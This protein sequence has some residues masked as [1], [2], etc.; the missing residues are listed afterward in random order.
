MPRPTHHAASRV[1]RLAGDAC[2]RARLRAQSP[3]RDGESGQALVEFALVL[4]V[5]VLFLAGIVHFGLALNGA[6]D[7]TN[8][9]EIGARYASVSQTC[10]TKVE[11]KATLKNG[12]KTITVTE[13][14]AK[15]KAGMELEGF[16]IPAKATLVK[17]ISEAKGEWEMSATATATVTTPEIVVA[18]GTPE[19][20][21][22]G[23]TEEK[24]FLEWLPRQGDSADI[25]KAAVTMCSPTSKLGDWVEVKIAY[26]YKWVPIL[27]LKV[28]ESQIAGNAKMR[29]EKEPGQAYPGTC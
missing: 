20:C 22:A 7:E 27:K 16:A 24:T 8:I 17:V 5:L 21:A 6:N 3:D 26:Q 15:L 1:R 14:F 9:A 4:P 10:G 28:A 12:S 2:R 13:G 29:I 25:R 19:S 11:A 18:W 23:V